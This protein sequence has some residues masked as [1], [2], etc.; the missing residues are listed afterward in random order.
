MS[1]VKPKG[2][3]SSSLIIAVIIALIIGIVAGYFIKPTAPPEVK[4]ETIEKTI[5]KTITKTIVATT[6]P[7]FKLP[8]LAGV[9]LTAVGPVGHPSSSAVKIAAEEFEKLTGAKIK[10]VEYDWA[11]LFPKIMT[12]FT[13]HSGV[14]DIIIYDVTWPG[15]V[16]PYVVDLGKFRK[17]HPELVDPNYDMDDWVGWASICCFYGGTNIGYPLNTHTMIIEYR[18][19]LLEDPTNKEEFKKKYGYELAPPTTWDQFRDIAEFFTG[20]HGCEYGVALMTKIQ[21]ANVFFNFFAPLRRSSE[22]I[23][24]FGKVN[25]LYG[26]WF[27]EDGKPALNNEYGLKA[28][29][30]FIELLKFAPAPLESDYPEADAYFM[31]G[32]CALNIIW[33]TEF[34][35]DALADPTSVVKDK[36]ACAV[37]PGWDNIYGYGTIGG[38]SLAINKDSKNKEAA[39]LFIQWMTSKEQDK[40]NFLKAGCEPARK[41]TY[42]DP[43]L[44]SKYPWLS[45]WGKSVETPCMRPSIPQG[46]DI[47][48][49]VQTHVTAALAGIE[50]PEKALAAMESEINKLLAG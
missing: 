42:K 36:T 6:T 22:G 38:Q 29:N 45:V 9:T 2:K 15:A 40:I 21:S 50:T 12:D 5:E 34:Y 27:T 30:Y 49:I 7:T 28:L 4:T 37:M 18:K 23:K 46:W 41:S 8:S 26:D 43:E 32:K 48:L 31:K 10:T 16:A 3:I 19:D 39:F 17:E 44:L 25:P 24:R 1:E 33:P 47:Y 20:A 11:D 35:P 14:Y 13:T